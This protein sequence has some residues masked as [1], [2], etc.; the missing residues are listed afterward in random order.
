MTLQSQYIW[1]VFPEHNNIMFE[2]TF[3]CCCFFSILYLFFFVNPP[4][5][6]FY[7]VTPDLL[8]KLFEIEKKIVKIFHSYT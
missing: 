7:Y 4:W 5:V 2:Y 1:G 8:I 6:N 3:T